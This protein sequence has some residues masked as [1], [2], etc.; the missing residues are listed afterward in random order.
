M[1]IALKMMLEKVEDD[2]LFMKGK[3]SYRG[4]MSRGVKGLEA[5]SAAALVTGLVHLEPYM[6]LALAMSGFNA[7]FITSLYILSI[8]AGIIFATL[9]TLR[10]LTIPRVKSAIARHYHILPKI[11][12][13]FL[14]LTAI[15]IILLH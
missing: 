7:S 3:N 6:L 14:I 9:T 1:A 2:K 10:A 4:G 8:S 13:L 15:S 12:A 11:S 5:V